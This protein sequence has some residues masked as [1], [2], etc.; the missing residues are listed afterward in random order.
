M[1]NGEIVERCIAYAA[2]T[3]TKPSGHRVRKQ[4]MLDPRTGETKSR[5]PTFRGPNSLEEARAYR[6]GIELALKTG[7]N[8]ELYLGPIDKNEVVRVERRSVPKQPVVWK[9]TDDTEAPLTI[10]KFVEQ[11]ELARI[12]E[13]NSKGDHGQKL[14][15]SKF[16]LP[17][18]GNRYIDDIKPHEIDE[19][20]YHLQRQRKDNGKPYAK[21]TLKKYFNCF[22]TICRKMA[23]RADIQNPADVDLLEFDLKRFR[24]ARTK[25]NRVTKQELVGLLLGL[26]AMHMEALNPEKRHLHQF[27]GR[28][29]RWYYA[30]FVQSL[31]GLRPSQLAF[32]RKQDLLYDERDKTYSLRLAGGI[33][34]GEVGP[35]KKGKLKGGWEEGV[36]FI[37]LSRPASE[38]I[39]EWLEVRTDLGF[40]DIE[41]IF[42]KRD[43]CL[44]D[45][46]VVLY[47][48]LC[49]RAEGQGGLG[50]VKSGLMV[51]LPINPKLTLLL[52]DGD[53]YDM[54]CRNGSIAEITTEADLRQLKRLQWASAFFNV[55][56][57]PDTSEEEARTYLEQ[58]RE[59][60]RVHQSRTEVYDQ[61][62]T[63]SEGVVFGIG[64]ERQQD[65]EVPVPKL[66]RNTKG[67]PN[68]GLSLTP[69]SLDP[70][71][72][73]QRRKNGHRSLAQRLSA[74]RKQWRE[75]DDSELRKIMEYSMGATAEK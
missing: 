58:A 22:R 3:K 52:Y 49:E 65:S 24:G 63:D 5:K 25:S 73:R 35:T 29:A 64:D 8:L 34:D 20:A 59:D 61:L 47:N 74:I 7:E 68:V 53:A 16:Y 44:S 69:L 31:T 21:S 72:R 1:K 75:F 15:A 9:A 50:Y 6:A 57:S 66:I 42:T 36:Q 48:K 71:L 56:L 46:P 70:R 4:D 17:I 45:H 33:V 13:F 55:Y 30:G 37:P 39:L 12:D 19:L 41:R 40:A 67:M 62:S 27:R 38:H 26:K 54:S 32:L 28:R 10:R 14:A 43:F 18:F 2:P 60:R 51:F 23:K 11:H